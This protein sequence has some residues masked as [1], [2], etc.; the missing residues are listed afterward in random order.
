[1]I[2]LGGYYLFHALQQINK[3]GAVFDSVSEADLSAAMHKMVLELPSFNI[4]PVLFAW[5]MDLVDPWFEL[6]FHLLST[7]LNYSTLMA[8]YR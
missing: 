6:T 2:L 3:I 4:D 1:M 7:T 8:Q 5:I